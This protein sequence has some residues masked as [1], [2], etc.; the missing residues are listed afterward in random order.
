MQMVNLSYVAKAMNFKYSMNI[1]IYD[2]NNVPLR[3][4][5]VVLSVNDTARAYGISQGYANAPLKL[6]FNTTAKR[7]KLTVEYDGRVM[8]EKEFLATTRDATIRLDE[9]LMPA[10]SPSPRATISQF[11]NESISEKFDDIRV[12]VIVALAEEYKVFVKYFRG[13]V[14][15]KFHIDGLTIDVLQREGESEKSGSFLSIAWGT[16]LLQSLQVAFCR[17]LILTSW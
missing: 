10:R 11:D 8:A 17:F 4:A 1:W 15:S 16:L 13:S 5:R 3:G 9:V 14:V 2:T 12:A 6:R 7:V